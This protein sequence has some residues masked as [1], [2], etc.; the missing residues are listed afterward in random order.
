MSGFCDA[1]AKL[2][3]SFASYRAPVSA[4]SRWV[5]NVI[6]Q[7][8]VG[9]RSVTYPCET[10]KP[11][12]QEF[13]TSPPSRGSTPNTHISLDLSPDLASCCRAERSRRPRALHSVRQVERRARAERSCV[14]VPDLV[15]VELAR[16]AQPAHGDAQVSRVGVDRCTGHVRLRSEP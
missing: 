4:H 3:T 14:P 15:R 10:G 6:A 12:Y 13:T 7:S 2:W 11:R 1:G 16:M 5:T 8:P 9:T